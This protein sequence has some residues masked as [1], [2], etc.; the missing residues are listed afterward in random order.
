MGLGYNNPP[1]TDRQA[2]DGGGKK[3]EVRECS[4]RE[5]KLQ[6]NGVSAHSLPFAASYSWHSPGSRATR[7]PISV[8][9]A[10]MGS[11]GK[12]LGRTLLKAPGP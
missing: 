3:E 6:I 4:L 5:D 2:T 1:S 11:E 8:G 12:S 10:A 9:G 7:V